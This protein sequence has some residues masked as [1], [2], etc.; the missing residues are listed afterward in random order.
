MN[1]IAIIPVDDISKEKFVTNSNLVDSVRYYFNAYL[2][3][4]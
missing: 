1:N 3:H 4:N 2:D